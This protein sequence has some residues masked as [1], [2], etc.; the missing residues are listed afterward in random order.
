MVSTRAI[1]ILLF[2]GAWTLV[3]F[4]ALFSSSVARK[5]RVLEILSGGLFILSGVIWFIGDQCPAPWAPIEDAVTQC[6]LMSTLA[7]LAAYW[8][9]PYASMCSLISVAVLSTKTIWPYETG[10]CGSW[11][12]T[13]S[14]VIG[15][16]VVV[17]V[18]MAVV[19]ILIQYNN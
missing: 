16:F 5:N 10:V 4:D 11:I 8:N 13:Y 18:L 15:A 14:V 2:F 3:E 9:R 7:F 12:V 17:R 6:I 1:G 19:D